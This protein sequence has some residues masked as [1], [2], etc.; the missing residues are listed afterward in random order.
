MADESIE[1]MRKRVAAHDLAVKMNEAAA[2]KPIGTGM[3]TTADSATNERVASNLGAPLF[4]IPDWLKIIAAIVV[5]TIPV[6][7]EF[8]AVQA[9]WLGAVAGLVVTLGAALGIVSP[10][11]RKKTP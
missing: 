1:E 7:A 2:S 11:A 3:L 5:V 9:P 4:V 10:G 6:L 8:F